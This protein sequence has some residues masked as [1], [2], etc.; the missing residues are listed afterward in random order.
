MVMNRLAFIFV[1]S[2]IS[3]CD[4]SLQNFYLIL[5]IKDF[6][7]QNCKIL[8]SGVNVIVEIIILIFIWNYLIFEE[9]FLS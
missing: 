2:S 3:F 4:I 1:G 7:I 6:I 5:S 9:L 8:Y